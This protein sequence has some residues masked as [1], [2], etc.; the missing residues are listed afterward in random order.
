MPG[1]KR[2]TTS[3]TSHLVSTA[4]P[5]ARPCRRVSIRSATA[6]TGR[7]DAPDWRAYCGPAHGALRGD[8]AQA[9]ARAAGAVP[10]VAPPASPARPSPYHGE[11]LLTPAPRLSLLRTRR[12]RGAHHH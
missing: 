9:G 10:R 5:A 6:L 11:L 1:R 12:R 3:A 8:A 4:A 2:R 7:P